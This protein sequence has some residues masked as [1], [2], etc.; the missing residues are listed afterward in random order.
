VLGGFVVLLALAVL[1]NGFTTVHDTKRAR[2]D[3]KVAARWFKSH[4]ELGRF[5]PPRVKDGG[6]KDLACASRQER[7]GG[8]NPID[9]YC[10]FIEDSSTTSTRVLASYR[11]YYPRAAHFRLPTRPRCIARHT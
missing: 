3:K 1:V 10:I 5:G 4:P 6:K 9:G 8:D 7:S 2:L 11:C